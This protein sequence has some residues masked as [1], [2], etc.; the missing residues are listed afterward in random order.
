MRGV[1]V[2]SVVVLVLRAAIAAQGPSSPDEFIKRF[3]QAFDKKDVPALMGMFYAEGTPAEV[4]SMNERMLKAMV[5]GKLTDV[6]LGPAAPGDD[7]EYVRNGV[8]YRPTLKPTGSLKVTM[9]ASGQG[10]SSMSFMVGVKDGAYYLVTSAASPA[11]GE[12]GAAK[13]VPAVKRPE[14][15]LTFTVWVAGYKGAMLLNKL[16]GCPFGP[17][18]AHPDITA[19]VS[20]ALMQN[21]VKDGENI[22]DVSFERL[23]SPGTKAPE[24]KIVLS[25]FPADF[26]KSQIKDVFKWDLSAE[27]PGAKVIRFTY[28]PPGQAPQA[29]AQ[30]APEPET[31][32]DA[33]ATEVGIL[34]N[35]LRERPKAAVA[36][37]KTY[38]ENVLKPCRRAL[39]IAP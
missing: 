20:C 24:L 6:T 26:P 39:G 21:K 9:P 23:A 22:L 29:E 5:Q 36:C 12:P 30:T 32:P 16:D 2:L 3:R 34:C 25:L 28:P 33:C 10:A 7:K 13:P 37:L 17:M 35:G 4:N 8:I 14:G 15:D 1:G 19:S 38:G 18:A 27:K 31:I 11:A